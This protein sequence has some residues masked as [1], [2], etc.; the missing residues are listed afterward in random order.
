MRTTRLTLLTLGLV[1]AMGLGPVVAD[2][3]EGPGKAKGK[4]SD[5]ERDEA[6][7]RGIRYLDR[8]VMKLPDSQGTPTKQFTVGV[9]GLVKLLAA[10]R[11]SSS[12]KAGTL[13]KV[14]SYLARYVAQ[15]KEGIKNRGRLPEHQ[16]QF[17][18]DRLIQY[19]WPVAMAGLFFGELHARGK[20]TGEARRV[21]KDVRTILRAAQNENGG[22]GHH[23]DQGKPANSPLGVGK[24]YPGTL[25]CTSWVVASTLG[26]LEGSEAKKL[27][28]HLAKALQYFRTAQLDNGNFPYDE[29]QRSAHRSMTGVSRAAGSC[30]ALWTLGM[31]W[32]DKSMQRSLYFIDGHFDYLNE[33]HGSSTLN[34]LYGALLL[35]VRG[36][37][38]W[39]RFKA[40]YFRPIVDGQGEDGSFECICERKAFGATHDTDPF[41]GKAMPGVK[42]V[43]KTAGNPELLKRFTQ[44]TKTAYVSAI[45]TLILLL[46]RTELKLLGGK[47]PKIPSGGGTVTTPR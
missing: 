15:V 26:L 12:G 29:S 7:L 34:L 20:H 43:R 1:L 22:W 19:T 39:K 30:F 2:A 35:R 24:G 42:R 21:L 4:V 27:P 47:R 37:R 9:T 36:S 28:A 33:G 6:I 32:H 14:R 13:A 23:Q 17:P 5:A 18:P 46:D 3:K 8:T 41:G 40:R 31:P 16:G 25:L 11:A 38:D 45:H 10:D 44:G